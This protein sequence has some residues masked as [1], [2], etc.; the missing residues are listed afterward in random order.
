VGN[1][2]HSEPLE[3]FLRTLRSGLE[4]LPHEES[5]EILQELR[6]HVLEKASSDLSDENIRKVLNELATPAE[7][8]R[9][10]LDM[11]G[12]APSAPNRR[13]SLL[14]V[15]G[16]GAYGVF[17][18]LAAAAGYAVAAC[19]IFTAPAKP[20]APNQVGLWRLA[21]PT[22]DLS[23]SPGRHGPDVIGRDLLGWWI[24]PLGI[25]VGI[26][27]VALA[28]RISRALIRAMRTPSTSSRAASA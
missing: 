15:L 16:A 4:I 20:F 1:V 12:T 21:D 13:L 14:R 27:L 2:A 18:A 5:S 24:I 26:G 9:I 8:A 28:N 19:W 6:C 22:G 17:A 7:L 10:N 11:R 25:G 3:A 23:L